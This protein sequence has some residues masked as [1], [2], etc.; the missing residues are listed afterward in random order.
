VGNV[1]ATL[2]HLVIQPQGGDEHHVWVD[3]L[4]RVIRVEV[5]ARAWRAERTQIPR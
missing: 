2:F 3:A 4:N 1:E 5:P